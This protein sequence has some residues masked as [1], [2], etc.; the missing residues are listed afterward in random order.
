MRLLEHRDNLTFA[1]FCFNPVQ[2]TGSS[3]L[4]VKGTE[5][6]G[7]EQWQQRL[8]STRPVGEI[9]TY[10]YMLGFFRLITKSAEEPNNGFHLNTSHKATCLC[11]LMSGCH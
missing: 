9:L 4:L 8:T 11:G 6:R 1:Y 2:I 7:G 3:A 5:N 10:A